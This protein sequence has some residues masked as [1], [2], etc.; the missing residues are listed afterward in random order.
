M[1]EADD[2]GERRAQFIRDVMEEV[3]LDLV[4][5][6]QRFVALAQGALDIDAVG[7]VL[8]RHQ[9][10]AIRQRQGR[11][12]DNAAVAAF[13][14]ALH[15]ASRWPM[16][17]TA[18]AQRAHGLVFAV[19]AATPGDDGFDMRAFGQ[20]LGRK[21]PHLGESRIVQPQTAVA[22]KH[23]DRFREIVER[24]ALHA[25]QRVIAAFEIEPFGDVVE[26][27]GH[28]AFGIRRRDDAQR[29]SVR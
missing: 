15:T 25:D 8:E 16:A 11:D 6:F 26:Q 19:A 4:G 9:C 14:A 18:R 17:V 27:V 1:R 5:G 12:I 3:D 28:A 21:F 24:L 2:V 13:E 29:P 10:S 22:R 7:D 20:R 23:R